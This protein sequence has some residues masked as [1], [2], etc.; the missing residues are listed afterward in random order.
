MQ[1]EQV[2][3]P[4]FRKKKSKYVS[5]SQE[6]DQNF[7]WLLSLMWEPRQLTHNIFKPVTLWVEVD[8]DENPKQSGTIQKYVKAQMHPVQTRLPKISIQIEFTQHSKV[9]SLSGCPIYIWF[10]VFVSIMLHCCRRH[11]PPLLLMWRADYKF[12]WTLHKTHFLITAR[13]VCFLLFFIGIRLTTSQNLLC[14][15]PLPLPSL[16]D[17]MDGRWPWRCTWNQEWWVAAQA[18]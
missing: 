13:G 18:L 4:V 3:M 11:L 12:I 17:A 10:A 6:V 15:H 16:A 14:S 5:D 7:A 9:Q 8:E 1:F 2:S